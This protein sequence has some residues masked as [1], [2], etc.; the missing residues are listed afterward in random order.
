MLGIGATRVAQRIDAA[1]GM[2]QSGAIQFESCESV[3]RGGLMCM[4]PFLISQ[5]L[6]SYR[7]Y[8]SEREGGYYNYDSIILLLSFMY[9]GRIKNPEKL[10][11]E[12]PGELGKLL[13]LDRVPEVRCLRSI[14]NELSQQQQSSNWNAYLAGEWIQE[15]NENIFYIDG[16]VQVYHGNL[17][18]LGKKHVSRQKLCLPGTIDFWVNN[19]EGNPYFYV[20]GE[21]NEKLQEMLKTQ[22]IEKIKNLSPEK[23]S[24]INELDNYTPVFTVIF[25]R[26]GYSPELFRQLWQEHKV[27]VI[28]YNKNVK[29]VWDEENFSIYEIVD[30]EGNKIEMELCEKEVELSGVKMREIRRKCDG[31]HQTSVITTNRKISTML[32]ALYM[33]ARWCQENFFRYMRLE[34][35][36]DKLIQY[37]IE[38]ID[39]DFKIVNPN[40]T[41]L[42][43]EIK[44]LREKISRR[45]A[46]LLELIQKNID[47]V[48]ENTNQNMQKQL[49]LQNEIE[50][51]KVKEQELLHKRKEIQYK[52]TIGEMPESTRYNK[53]LTECKLLQNVI[54]FICYRAE[55]AF[56]N[57]I[58]EEYKR[59]THEKRA[60]FKSL[61]HTKADIIPDYLNKTL[62]II[63]YSLSTPRDNRAIEKTLALLND[64]ETVFPGTEL[65]LIYKI[66]SI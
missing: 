37:G 10:K 32:I 42:T 64:T 51:H 48:L 58:D 40:H 55:T 8:Y 28:T 53:L 65:R 39:I 11:H 38:Q 26:E 14:F 25:D 66:T 60:L 27:A 63:I 18:N 3:S 52:I 16:H 2:G 31:G 1:I 45:Q 54:K 62:T 56:V 20:T 7:S 59:K 44:K 17:A 35:D 43:Y 29:D 30:N 57:L 15:N 34:Y 46:Q 6:L 47:N 22:I 36:I 49:K 9:L 5:G 19:V 33:F 50:Q 21:V 12:S 41:K 24:V 13:G 4:L 61:T 23:F